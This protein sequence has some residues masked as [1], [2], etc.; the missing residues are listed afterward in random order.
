MLE[1]ARQFVE[2][3]FGFL[4]IHGSYGNGKTCVLQAIINEFRLR[5][6]IIGTYI[7]FYDLLEYIRAGFAQD[8]T[9]DARAR[10]HRLRD[11]PIL[12]VDE[13]DAPRS[14]AYAEEFRRAFFDDRYRLAIVRSA[15]TVFG[16][17]CAPASL[18]G[19]LYDRLRDGRFHILHNPD[20]SMRPA[21]EWQNR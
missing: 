20:P 5:Y 7:R 1:L 9:D 2:E 21:M 14:T 15:H 16:L 6:N 11:L 18:P 10:Y 8:A 3:P 19:D 13:I 12:A 17:N 4:T